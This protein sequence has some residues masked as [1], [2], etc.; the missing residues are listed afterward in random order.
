[1]GK[2]EDDRKDRAEIEPAPGR[3]RQGRRRLRR[4][5]HFSFWPSLGLALLA[6]FL[7]LASMAATGREVPLPQ[8]LATRIE[9]RLNAALPSGGITLREVDFGMSPE[10][11]P[12]LSLIGLGLKDATGLEV[13]Q[14]HRLR[15]AFKP[16]PL[17]RGELSPARLSLSGAEVTLRRRIDGTFD[18]SFGQASGASGDL[19]GLL[20]AIDAVFSTAPMSGVLGVGADDLTITLEDARTGRIWQVTEG[21]L[22]LSQTDTF[23]DITVTFDVFNQTEELA[24]VVLGFRTDKASSAAS[25]S[26]SFQ[27]AAAA[28]IA[29][30]SPLLAFLEVLDAPIS[31]AL[32]S[33]IDT[34]GALSE[35]AGT[36]E[37]GPGAL[38]PTPGARPVRFD[39]AKV[40]LDYAPE[41]GRLDFPSISMR[42]EL[43]EVSGSGQIY[44]SDFNSGWPGTFLGQVQIDEARI[45]AGK[46]FRGAVE[47]DEGAADFRL[48]LNPFTLDLGQ[49]VL[50]QAGTAFSVSGQ[51]SA[52][53]EGWTLAL[54]GG[55]ETMDHTQALTLWPLKVAPKARAWV[56]K[57]VRS[58]TLTGLRGALR[59]A[60]GNKPRMALEAGFRDFS[61]SV[62]RAMAPMQ[63]ASG[64]MQFRDFSFLAVAEQGFVEA[65]EGGRI[66]LGGSVFRVNDTRLKPAPAKVDLRFAGPLAATLSLLDGPPFHVF[67]TTA[68]GPDIATGQVTGSGEAAFIMKP[69]LQPQDVTFSAAA[70]L[71]RVRSDKLVPDK[72]VTA[73]KLRVEVDNRRL[74]ISGT[75][76]VGA[77]RGTGSWVAPIGPAANGTSR[78]E[79]DVV[80]DPGALDEFRVALP[81]G[82]VSGQGTGRLELDFARDR[83]PAYRLR[84]DLNRLGLRIP[85]IGWSKPRNR[86]GRLMISGH[87]TRPVEVEKLEFS[88]PGLEATGQVTLTPDG[89]FRQAVFDRVRLGWLDAPVTI[90][91]RGPNQPVAISV[92]GG[93]ADMSRAS[94]GDGAGGGGGAR[95]DAPIDLRLDRLKV[96]EGIALT[97]LRADLDRK[98]GLHGTFRARVNGGPEIRGVV[99]PQ[100]RGTAF[101]ITSQDA[102]GVLEA[103]DVFKSARGGSMTL[104]LAPHAGEGVYDGQLTIEKIRSVGAPALSALLGAI[105]VVGLLEQFQQ[106]GILFQEVKARFR[107]TPKQVI[108]TKG[109]AVGASLGVSMDGTYRLGVGEMDLAGVISPLYILNGLGQIFTRKGEG[110]I[111]F[112]YTLKGT[113]DNPQ[114]KVNPLS[115]FTPAMFRELFRKPP[116]KLPE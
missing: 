74:E 99:A 24:S 36:L 109:S 77:A 67:K 44:L 58:G 31:G 72:E 111:G 21:R 10:G 116:P 78:L 32:R 43:G 7:V 33:A 59:V 5:F 52:S 84:S 101:R 94:F 27:N 40:Y 41:E 18:L 62:V 42:S 76:Q 20:D 22:K 53:R 85:E 108:I 11:V 14:L 106:E 83:A 55:A 96:T 25:I 1:M 88:A 28:D 61:A 39:T 90:T 102:G 75:A 98:G 2:A 63:A 107:L 115:I 9:A 68:F 57:N 17:L 30:Q 16:G 47:I 12:R 56:E 66:R 49:V 81:P 6:L 45:A 92:S 70:V 86:T 37:L 80:L 73:A 34:D 38:S 110:L 112:T 89:G 4:A 50:V 3:A 48:D 51:V 95:G 15:A 35:L 79:A 69:H 46:L 87:L 54:D 104:T 65:P 19:A 93:Q 8:W 13:A 23:V 60:P 113:P 114:V 64:Y 103:A 82:T 91:G 97:G 100:A 105:S 71:S 29:A 26:A